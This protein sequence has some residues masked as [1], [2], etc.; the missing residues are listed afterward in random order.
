MCE[1]CRLHLTRDNWKRWTCFLQVRHE[2]ESFRDSSKKCASFTF[3]TN[4]TLWLTDLHDDFIGQTGMERICDRIGIRIEYGSGSKVRDSDWQSIGLRSELTWR[5]ELLISTLVLQRC[6]KYLWFSCDRY[7]FPQYLL[8]V[9]RNVSYDKRINSLHEITEFSKQIVGVTIKLFISLSSFKIDVA[10]ILL[11]LVTSFDRRSVLL[12]SLISAVPLRRS[13]ATLYYDVLLLRST[14]AL[15]CFAQ[16]L[17]SA[18]ILY[19][20]AHR[21]RIRVTSQWVKD[22]RNDNWQRYNEIVRTTK[23]RRLDLLDINFINYWEI[24]ESFTSCESIVFFVHD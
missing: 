12:C 9:K 11:W 23:K 16:L 21:Y 7:Y 19:H 10:W 1:Y 18:V 17:R 2:K 15:H 22:P 3:K 5:R 14:T 4:C 8:H 6:E 20:F 24:S 13:T